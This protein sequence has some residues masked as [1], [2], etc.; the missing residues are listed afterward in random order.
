MSQ[1]L[2]ALHAHGLTGTRLFPIVMLGV[3]SSFFSVLP[4]QVL[5]VGIQIVSTP[6]EA[7]S[8]YRLLR[9]LAPLS[10]VERVAICV[11]AFLSVSLVAVVLRNFFSYL[12]TLLS[13]SVVA[14]FQRHLYSAYLGQRY[15]LLTARPAGELNDHLAVDCANLELLISQ[16]LYTAGSDFF[17][18]C[19]IIVITALLAW[20]LP[21]ALVLPLPLMVVIARR[22]A[23]AQR[24]SMREIRGFGALMSGAAVSAFSKFESVKAFGGET[25][26][27]KRYDDLVTAGLGAER[28]VARRLGYFFSGQGLLQALTT[29]AI[30]GVWLLTHQ[31][32]FGA[33]TAILVY[34]YSVRF[35]TPINNVVR[36]FQSLQRGSVSLSRVLMELG[37]NRPSLEPPEQP[38]SAPDVVGRA[39]ISLRDVRV[40]RGGRCLVS[41]PSVRVD[42]GEV[43]LLQG[44][45]GSGKSTL[46]KAVMGLVDLTGGDVSIDNL[47]IWDAHQ[48]DWAANFS[49][50]SQEVGLIGSSLPEIVEYPRFAESLSADGQRWLVELGLQG[51][52]HR[53]ADWGRLSGGER[54][55]VALMRAILRPAPIL[56]LDEIDANVDAASES[57]I[58]SAVSSLKSSRTILLISHSK[59]TELLKIVDRVVTL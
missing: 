54:R 6:N 14:N 58:W 39:S 40:C 9:P 30:A 55:R 36:Y 15:E 50:A 31:S 28:R 51:L 45:N 53:S 56:V 23:I 43:L 11:A 26:E 42:P 8:N 29:S 47:S 1:K 27:M 22:V 33:T 44:P 7:L 21:L 3:L 35:Y 48:K 2:R 41:V 59:S 49:Y 37:D 24:S 16:P 19:W 5:V 17:D 13:Q 32:V 18:M 57:L 38:I 52:A 25:T 12:S 46:V 34:Q 20:W 10:D 4:I